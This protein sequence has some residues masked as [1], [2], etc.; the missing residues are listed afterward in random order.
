MD[1]AIKISQFTHLFETIIAPQAACIQKRQ[2][3]YSN[4]SYI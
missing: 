2:K 3:E 4:F 1:A